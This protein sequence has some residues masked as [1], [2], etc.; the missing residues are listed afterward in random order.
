M[1]IAPVKWKAQLGSIE[2]FI[3]RGANGGLIITK[4]N[5][6]KTFQFA[7]SSIR[8]IRSFAEIFDYIA[9]WAENQNTKQCI[10]IKEEG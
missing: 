9:K 7:E 2:L 5:G 6:E 10:C 4:P 8:T 1:E 3:E